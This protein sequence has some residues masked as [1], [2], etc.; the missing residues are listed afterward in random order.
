MFTQFFCF[1]DTVKHSTDSHPCLDIP[2]LDTVLKRRDMEHEKY[3]TS[4]I[5][6][7]DDNVIYYKSIANPSSKHVQVLQFEL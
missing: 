3:S 7:C 6:Q 4:V 5:S 2:C 1:E